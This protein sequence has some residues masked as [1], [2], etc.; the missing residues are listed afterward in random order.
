MHEKVGRV[1]DAFEEMIGSNA[2]LL[3]C[4]WEMERFNPHVT[5]STM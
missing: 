5:S 3:V 1:Y 2:S 4:K